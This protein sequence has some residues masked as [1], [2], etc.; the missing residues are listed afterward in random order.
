MKIL[1]EPITY[2]PKFTDL[3]YLILE[4]VYYDDIFEKLTEYILYKLD[5]S[6]IVQISFNDLLSKLPD[7]WSG[8]RYFKR[9]KNLIVVQVYFKNDDEIN[10]VL[11]KLKLSKD[12]ELVVLQHFKT[13]NGI[14]VTEL[15]NYD[16]KDII[17]FLNSML[18]LNINK[19][20]ET[21]CHELIHLFQEISGRSK[22]KVNDKK[23]F[24]LSK[25]DKIEI[26]NI[27][28]LTES[29]LFNIFSQEELATYIRDFYSLVK[30]ETGFTHKIDMKLFFIEM[31]SCF[32]ND[33]NSKSF[34]DYFNKIK[35]KIIDNI[36][37]NKI[38]NNG[39]NVVTNFIIVAYY[40]N[41]GVN[42]IKNH[43]YGYMN[44]D[45]SLK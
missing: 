42:T 15:D 32:H 34:K 35:S 5:N 20:H 11:S 9:E 43:L 31:D 28:G 36:H 38:F 23:L 13:S 25:E 27:L 29:A 19:R 21:L 41:L 6:N 1:H 40:L 44:K 26:K 16:K 30:Q 22:Y 24:N 18:Q 33:F 8:K 4:D 45:N 7:W 3:K 37:I 17:I 12:E 10:N 39:N 2:K 14:F